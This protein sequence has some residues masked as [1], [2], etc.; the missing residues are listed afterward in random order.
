MIARSYLFVPGHRRRMLEKAFTLGADEVVIDLEDAVPAQDEPAARAAARD[1]LGRHR[2]WVRIN[3]V[4]TASAEADLAAVAGL[5][6]GIR[7]PKVESA[8]DIRWVAARVPAG[9]EFLC[10]IETARG[11]LA[12]PDI[13]AAPGVTRLA[14]GGLDLR[15]D[16][17]C[18]ATPEALLYSRG[19]LVVASR[20]NGLEAPID[21]VYPHV[22][23]PDGLESEA[24]RARELG[25]GA[26][27]AIHP[28]QLSVIHRTFAPDADEIAWATA[29]LEALIASEGRPTTLPDGEFVDPPVEARARRIVAN[30]TTQV[31][32]ER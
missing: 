4:R 14:M 1:A 16:L 22:T 31:L 32:S 28:D 30:A 20:A 25:F 2:A 7:I 13:A 23:D 29:V 3:A 15:T 12:A 17:R 24:R 5:A 26:K 18:G 6:R 27:S 8:E 11:V 10:A 9:T 21:S 19:A